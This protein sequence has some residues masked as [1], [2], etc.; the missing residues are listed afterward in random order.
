MYPKTSGTM[1]WWRHYLSNKI[2]LALPFLFPLWFIWWGG[3]S[4]NIKLG[5]R[6]ERPFTKRPQDT[7]G[8]GEQLK[9]N[10]WLLQE[11]IKLNCQKVTTLFFFFNS[12]VWADKLWCLSNISPRQGQEQTPWNMLEWRGWRTNI[13][14]G[15]TCWVCSFNI[16]TTKNLSYKTK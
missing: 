1:K 15:R 2:F 13:F 11:Q 6:E 7:G 8:R 9:W 4:G 3:R 16:E 14:S 12:S 5:N 10:S